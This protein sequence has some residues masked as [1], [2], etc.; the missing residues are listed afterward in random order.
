MISAKK[1]QRSRLELCYYH[2]WVRLSPLGTAATTWPLYQLQMV[3]DDVCGAIGGMKIGRG[4]LSTR[5]K[6]ALMPLCP[7]E[8]P[9]ELNRARTWTAA[10]GSRGITA[11]ATAQPRLERIWRDYICRFSNKSDNYDDYNNTTQCDITKP[12]ASCNSPSLA[13]G[14]LQAVQRNSMRRQ[15]KQTRNSHWNQ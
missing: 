7:P 13:C 5:R 15:C 2:Q 1:Y 9:H 10:V 11:W 6:P 12:E 8:I 14:L 3:D 4:K